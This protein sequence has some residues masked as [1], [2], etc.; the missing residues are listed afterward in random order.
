MSTY[1]QTLDCL[2][3]HYDNFAV[4]FGG[5]FLVFYALKQK[6]ELKDTKTKSFWSGILTVLLC[7]GFVY[8]ALD[9]TE[10]YSFYKANNPEFIF[11]PFKWVQLFKW[12]VGIM[13]LVALAFTDILLFRNW[14]GVL[15]GIFGFLLIIGLVSK[16]FGLYK[17]SISTCSTYSK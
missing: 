4:F 5:L 9:W 8:M 17:N 6:S 12:V 14:R 13:T 2:T 1:Q 16:S 15:W 7:V 3:L 10:N 11:G